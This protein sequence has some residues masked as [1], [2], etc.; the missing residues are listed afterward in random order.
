MTR[1]LGRTLQATAM[2]AATT[3]A[4]RSAALEG[5]ASVLA[6][7]SRALLRGRFIGTAEDVVRL[8][9]TLEGCAWMLSLSSCGPIRGRFVGVAEDVVRLAATTIE[10]DAGAVSFGGF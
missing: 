4:A 1:L 2:L 3:E 7:S 6:L 5:C 9:F 8:R 10:D